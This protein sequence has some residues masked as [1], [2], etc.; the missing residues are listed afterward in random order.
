MRRGSMSSDDDISDEETIGAGERTGGAS[1]FSIFTS[2]S[3][4]DHVSERTGGELLHSYGR[5]GLGCASEALR[6]AGL[7]AS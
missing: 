6:C 7:C 1:G 4:A 3:L 5:V 2:K